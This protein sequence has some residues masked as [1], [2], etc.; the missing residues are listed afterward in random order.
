MKVFP[1]I[2]YLIT[3]F[4]FFALLL[5]KGFLTTSSFL[6]I[7]PFILAM[8]GGFMY[9]TVCD[10]EKDP[11]EKNPITKGELSP[12]VVLSCSAMSTLISLGLFILFY[13]SKTALLLSVAYIFLWLA[14]SGLKIRF[15]ESYLA[16][17]VA[18][19]VLWS[20]GPLIL[21]AEFNYFDPVTS[22]LLL[23]IFLTYV[24]FEIN[25]T[26]GDYEIDLKYHC[27][28]FAVRMGKKKAVMV[29]H[30][31][32]ALGYSLLS[33]GAYYWSTPRSFIPIFLFLFPISQLLMITLD[34]LDFS[35]AWKVFPKFFFVSPFFI[36][37]L[38]IVLYSLMVLALPATYFL[39]FIWIFLTDKQSF[40]I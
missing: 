17:A 22:S 8:A 32:M 18:S 6:L 19:F 1:Y 14:Y 29:K 38:F 35:L 13:T 9:N 3:F 2:G 25:H 39:L 37:K 26:V 34:K 28:T 23:G 31:T 10:A 40:T 5:S 7:S 21:L 30:I 20:G 33:I 4:P 15:K 16:P 24:S 12:R 27:R 11:A 36:I